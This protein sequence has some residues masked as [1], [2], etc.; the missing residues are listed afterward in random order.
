[1]RGSES[2]AWVEGKTR[3]QGRGERVNPFA[4]LRRITAGRG[5]EGE[6]CSKEVKT[7][8]LPWNNLIYGVSFI[9]V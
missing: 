8:T 5:S 7:T 3:R 6:E 1:M 9:Y 2:A 4:L